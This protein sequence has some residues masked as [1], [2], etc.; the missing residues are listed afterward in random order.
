MLLQLSIVVAMHL[1][2]HSRGCVQLKHFPDTRALFLQTDTASVLQETI[3]Y[4]RFLLGQ[5]EVQSLSLSLVCSLRL[6][7]GGK[8]SRV[9]VIGPPERNMDGQRMYPT[10]Q[11]GFLYLA[12]SHGCGKVAVPEFTFTEHWGH[13]VRCSHTTVQY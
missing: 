1:L 9:M 5:I 10:S 3:G 4:I 8:S 13:N 7:R 2:F 11:Y 12:C 6:L